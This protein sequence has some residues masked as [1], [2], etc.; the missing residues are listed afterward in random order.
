MLEL[1]QGIVDETNEQFARV[2]QIKKFRM[3]PKELDHEDGE[4]TATQKVK[5][6]A[7][8]EM[9]GPLVEDMYG[10]PPAGAGMDAGQP[11]V[12]AP[13]RGGRSRMTQFVQTVIAGLGQGSLYALLGLG[14]VIIYKG[15][16]R[17]VSFAQPALMIAGATVVVLTWRLRRPGGG[18]PWLGFARRRRA[19]HGRHRGS[20]AGDR[21]ARAA[22]DGRR[23]GVRRSRS[24][25]SAC[26]SRSGW[27]VNRFI[28][29][30]VRPVGDP[31]GLDR[32]GGRREHRRPAPHVAMVLIAAR[33]GRWRSSRSSGTR[34]GAWR[35]GRP[36]STRRPRWPRAS[37]S[38][39]CS[40]CRGRSPAA[41]AAIAGD[42]RGRGRRL[43]PAA[44]GSSR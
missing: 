30:D 22:A 21:A 34:A 3:L 15:T 31:W 38:G 4:L 39:G 17:R 37:P 20:R 2:E 18:A 41:L 24:S 29:L 6:A 10:G 35:C 43:R 28:G 9:F 16:R 33:R 19:R 14:F 44:R 23:A 8:A 32:V 1:V 11:V 7:L 5:R 36:R 42:V 26:T 40:R 12:P 25:R 13:H 27:P